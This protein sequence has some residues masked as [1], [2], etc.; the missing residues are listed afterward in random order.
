[1]PRHNLTNADRTGLGEVSSKSLR[2]KHGK[3]NI[4]NPNVQPDFEVSSAQNLAGSNNI[5]NMLSD[6]ACEVE[7]L[8]MLKTNQLRKSLNRIRLKHR[9]E[10]NINN[11]LPAVTAL[12]RWFM[13]YQLK[14]T[15]GGD[16]VIPTITKVKLID[17]SPSASSDLSQSIDQ[18]LVKDLMIAKDSQIVAKLVAADIIKEA[19]KLST[20]LAEASKSLLVRKSTCSEGK[21]EAMIR[22][23]LSIDRHKHTIDV[24]Y[25]DKLLKINP[26]HYDKLKVLFQQSTCGEEVAADDVEFHNRL[27]CVLARYHAI[28]GHGFQAAVCEQ[29]F[30][31][32]LR[33]MQVSFECFASPL[34]S[35]YGK[36]CSAFP[37]TD[38][39]F[40]SVGSFF[41]F[42][43]KSG[44][45]EANPPF[46]P[47]VML[48][49]I[50]HIHKLL[51]GSKEPMSFVIIVPGWTECESW[52]LIDNSKY[53]TRDMELLAKDDH[54]FCDGASHQRRDRYRDSCFDTAVFFLQNAQGKKSYPVTD[55]CVMELKSSMAQGK[56]SPSMRLR[57]E[58]E[59]RGTADVCRG[60]YKGKKRNATGEG[61]MSRKAAERTGSASST[62][63]HQA[64][65]NKHKRQK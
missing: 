2:I 23:K 4:W 56:P 29:S 45:F 13:R 62:S 41:D 54:G 37:D 39:Y 49:M 58:K 10:T 57:Q 28:Q 40:G 14:G 8:R 9:N 43:P 52:G 42:Y 53:K 60:V 44:S 6:V 50:N 36:Y 15:A 11:L 22:T 16:P 30:D 25:Q 47:V 59:G 24:K 35:R 27:F 5:E 38:V 7:Y 51:D 55:Q 18:G 3:T 17:N 61:V 46:E 63:T 20:E 32:L 33:H 31:A 19:S 65:N 1:M 64:A 12:E 48:K 26:L 34:N 21:P